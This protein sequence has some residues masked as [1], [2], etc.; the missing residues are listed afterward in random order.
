LGAGFDRRTTDGTW[1]FP[2]WG[3]THKEQ[4]E[5]FTNMQLACTTPDCVIDHCPSPRGTQ[6][7]TAT[8]RLFDGDSDQTPLSGV[9]EV[10]DI[11][12]LT[13]AESL[14]VVNRQVPV[15]DNIGRWYNDNRDA[16]ACPT[17]QDSNHTLH[18]YLQNI[19]PAAEIRGFG[20][21]NDSD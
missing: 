17:N 15:K 1:G 5:L 20:L 21:W 12:S 19:E 6:S 7:I 10:G 18:V 3:T 14:A 4:L 2:G 16:N 13:D 8:V 11:V 9:P